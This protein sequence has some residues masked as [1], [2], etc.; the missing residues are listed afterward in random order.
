[1]S[2]I[3]LYF[4]SANFARTW[5]IIHLYALTRSSAF[6]KSICTPSISPQYTVFLFMPFM[7]LV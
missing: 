5:S 7:A 1:M 6:A 3:Y 4:A 2:S